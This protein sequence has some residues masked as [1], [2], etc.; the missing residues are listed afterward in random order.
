MTKQATITVPLDSSHPVDCSCRVGFYDFILVMEQEHV[1]LHIKG[2]EQHLRELHACLSKA[3]AELPE[4]ET[5]E[6][7]VQGAA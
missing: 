3:I 1:V 7:M 4:E 5:V 2:T 6:V